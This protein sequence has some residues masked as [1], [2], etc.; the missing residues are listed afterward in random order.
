MKIIDRN[1]NYGRNIVKSFLLRSMPFSKVLD[2]GAGK[3]ADLLNAKQINN[4]A[5]LYAIDYNSFNLE[6]LQDK[7]IKTFKIDIEHEKIPLADSSVDVVIANQILEHIKEV[8]WVWHEISRVLKTGGKLIVGVPNLASFHNRV[9]LLLGKQPTCIQNFSAHI[10]GYT[11]S[12]IKKFLEN[13]WEGYKILSFKG[14]N[15]YPF[16]PFLAVPLS[17]LFPGMA[18]SIF[19]LLEK[20]KEYSGEFIIYVQ[21]AKLETNFFIPRTQ[22]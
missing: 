5:I 1:L 2:I 11:L 13:C 7:G 22:K 21:K 17:K 16:P 8:F 18:V 3:G 19:L 14:S 9:L 20:R 10:R 15:F 12:D 6:Y 4:K